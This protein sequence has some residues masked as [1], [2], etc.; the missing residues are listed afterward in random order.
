MILEKYPSIEGLTYHSYFN[1]GFDDLIESKILQAWLTF[2]FYRDGDSSRFDKSVKFSIGKFQGN[3]FDG[4]SL[5]GDDELRKLLYILYWVLIEY[6]LWNEKGFFDFIN[7]KKFNEIDGALNNNGSYLFSG[8]S[9]RVFNHVIRNF[10]NEEK[11]SAVYDLVEK[12][13]KLISDLTKRNL[14]VNKLGKHVE[15]L[16]KELDRIEPEYQGRLL[17][18]SFF[19]MLK[20]VNRQLLWSKIKYNSLT[21]FSVIIPVLVFLF[22]IYVSTLPVEH[23]LN[24][25]NLNNSEFNFGYFLSYVVPFLSLEIMLFYFVRLSYRDMNMLNAQK[26]QVEHRLAVSRFISSYARQKTEFYEKNINETYK[27]AINKSGDLGKFI[28]YPEGFENLIFSPIQANGENIPSAL[29]SVNSIAELA[30]K[31]MSAKK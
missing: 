20:G 24:K 3:I 12:N 30:G 4:D 21:F 10:L 22:H 7:E 31:V 6:S 13:N 14:L 11:L 29:D 23:S 9:E 17:T 15:Y 25:I 2:K 16:K 5:N 18:K 27:D 1:R 19:L 8:M 28:G 26:L